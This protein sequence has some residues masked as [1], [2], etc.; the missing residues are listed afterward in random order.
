MNAIWAEWVAKAET[1]LEAA[2]VLASRRKR[3]LPDQVCFLSQQCAEK[4]L[5]AFLIARGIVPPKVHNLGRL[6]DM[7]GELDS[8]YHTLRADVEALNPYGVDIRYPGDVATV[9]DS[10]QALTAAR[11]IQAFTRSKLGAVSGES[12]V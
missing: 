4:Y 10:R 3:P 9:E 8:E 11:R 1:D 2:S 7:C 6:N 12:L 5:K